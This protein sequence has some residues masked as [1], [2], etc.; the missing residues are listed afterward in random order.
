MRKESEE[1][2]GGM[3]ESFKQGG[4]AFIGQRNHLTAKLCFLLPTFLP[5]QRM[6]ECA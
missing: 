5:Q 6:E 4:V 3:R 2:E 1:K